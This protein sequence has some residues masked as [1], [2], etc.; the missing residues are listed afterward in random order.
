[1]KRLAVFL[2]YDKKGMV[3]N[4]IYYLLDAA[5]AI[6][7]DF[8]IVSNNTLQAKHLK[9]IKEYGEVYQRENI[10]YDAGG[11]KDAICN[12]IGREKLKQYD[13]IVF[14]ND[15]FFGPL[16]SID[17]MFA[18]MDAR[19]ELDFWGITKSAGNSDVGEILQTYFW[20]V[21]SKMLNSDDFYDYWAKMPYYKSFKDVVMQYERKFAYTFSQK[22]FLWDSYIDP[23]IYMGHAKNN[24]M[25]PYHCLPFEIV[26]N[27]KYPFIKKKLFSLDYKSNEY[28]LHKYGR[29]EFLS[30]L[31]YIKECKYPED[32]IWENIIRIYSLRDIQDNCCEYNVLNE[33]CIQKINAKKLITLYVTNDNYINDR[34]V[35]LLKRN[36]NDSIIVYCDS[37]KIKTKIVSVFQGP[38][39][40][41]K[42]KRE[43]LIDIFEL[44]N[45][46]RNQYDYIA[47]MLEP[48]IKKG[49][50]DSFASN[51]T[52]AWNNWENMF[53]KGSYVD[54]IINLFEDNKRYGLL[55]LPKNIHG[56]CI[57]DLCEKSSIKKCI[58]T[59]LDI[60]EYVSRDRYVADYSE[61]FWIR[62]NIIDDRFTK[63]V[64]D[65]LKTKSQISDVFK[66]VPYYA[67][68][69]GYYTTVVQSQLFNRSTQKTMELYG[70]NLLKQLENLD[71]ELDYASFTYFFKI[72]VLYTTNISE[73]EKFLNRKKN[74]YIYGCGL[75]ARLVSNFKV[76]DTH[77]KGYIVS[78]GKQKQDSFCGKSVFYVSEL[79]PSPENGVVVALNHKNSLEIKNKLLGMYDDDSI[80]WLDARE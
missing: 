68:K 14:F 13:E 78:D 65:Y 31:D 23:Y 25:S 77:C 24:Y 29:N 7:E 54:N 57:V 79:K 47:I 5:R 41:K 63:V 53:G 18:E 15:S 55:A 9:N 3:D 58:S 52:T 48:K 43:F 44:I 36:S 61:S 22:G 74:I 62:S 64:I 28:G 80:F 75:I 40:V 56:E 35:P 2:T 19:K 71:I 11:F 70:R 59:K 45:K 73:L 51:A 26:K 38:V 30:L 10:G 66:V 27:Q 72:L 6:C 20:V 46:I 4:Y 67:Q 32:Y 12:Y 33:K 16:F 42:T 76:I 49:K 21:R 1:M 60:E 37:E 50:N 8:V 34:V 39:I 69:K 17:E